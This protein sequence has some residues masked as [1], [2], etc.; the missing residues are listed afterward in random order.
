MFKLERAGLLRNKQRLVSDTALSVHDFARVAA[1]LKAAPV[2]AR[3]VG[4][5]A[6]KQAETA[7]HFETRWNG[8]ESEITAEP[9]DWI[10][11]ALAKSGEPL[12]DAESNV[13]TYAIKAARFGDL[14]EPGDGDTAH[15]R[16]FK[17]KGIVQAI[18]LSGGFAIKAP[19]GEVQRADA[20]YLLLNGS[21]V[22]GNHK[23]TFEA[24]YEVVR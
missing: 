15:G 2:R 17:P 1:K 8:K 4:A 13:N 20:G 22:Y 7:Q 6:A 10:V 11:T 23:D 19:W 18:F 16:V 14:Y 21:D 5:V 12:R 24:T 3:K 9:G